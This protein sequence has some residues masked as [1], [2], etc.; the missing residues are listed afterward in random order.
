MPTLPTPP[1]LPFTLFGNTVL[2]LLAIIAAYFLLAVLLSLLS[3]RIASW[4][5]RLRQ[6]M[7]ARRRMTAERRQTLEGLIGSVISLLAF[8][9]AVLAT[10]SLFVDAQT[11]VW[12]AG[13]FSAAFGLGARGLVADILAGGRFIFRNTFAIGEKVEINS[14]GTL[15]EGM[16]EGVNVTN[17]M[18]RAPTGE[19]FTVPNG[20]IG[21]IRN[22]SRA[23]F[24][25]AKIRLQVQAEQIQ[26]ALDALEQMRPEISAL[27]PEL[28]E[29]WQVFSTSEVMGKKAELTIMLH[30]SFGKAAPL[31]LQAFGLI[32]RRLRAAGIELVD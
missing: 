15:I 3:R 23:P 16:V 31:R 28:V 13:L 11:L 9:V 5:L 1:D 7:P 18:V 22:F 6:L 30:T 21:V 8:V 24:S 14:A 19:L 25:S 17:T 27:L 20:D 12:I 10:L 26:P 32:H 29:P 4:L 2:V